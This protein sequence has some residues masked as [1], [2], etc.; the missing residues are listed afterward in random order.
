MI[1]TEQ[2]IDCLRARVGEPQAGPMRGVRLASTDSLAGYSRGI[3][4][5]NLLYRDEGYAQSSRWR[6]LIGHP[7]FLRYV[8][9]GEGHLAVSEGDVSDPLAGAAGAYAGIAMTFFRPVRPGERFRVRGG[10]AN[11]EVREREDGRRSVHETND[12][13]IWTS[14]GRLVGV[15]SERRIRSERRA[16]PTLDRFASL[17]LSHVY[18]PDELAEIDAEYLQEHVQGSR[19]RWYEDVT[20]GDEAPPLIKGPWTTSTYLTFVG[21]AGLHASR[22]HYSH[23]EAVRIRR[24]NPAAFPRD[25]LGIP[26][27][28]AAI[29]H[30]AFAARRVGLPA[31][32]ESGPERIAAMSHAVTNWMGDDA[33]L[34]RFA[35]SLRGFVFHGDLY[36]IACSVADKRLTERGCEVDLRLQATNQRHESVAAGSATVLVPSRSDGLPEVPV[37]HSQPVS[38][39]DDRTT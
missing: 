36:R 22:F 32:V 34:Y 29:H 5:L 2:A 28:E 1:I 37:E 26:V 21:G 39:F 35:V 12:T 16:S 30:D 8:G 25:E 14:E 4:D 13:V 31:P 23:S 20:V 24:T 7:T 19:P 38:I 27:T 3:G 17:D 33:F 18:E 15:I 6:G 10:L 11:L 9:D